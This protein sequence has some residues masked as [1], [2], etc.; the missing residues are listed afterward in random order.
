VFG[1]ESLFGHE[2]V[3]VKRDFSVLPNPTQLRRTSRC[4]VVTSLVIEELLLSILHVYHN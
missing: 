2:G 4:A 3:V 1:H